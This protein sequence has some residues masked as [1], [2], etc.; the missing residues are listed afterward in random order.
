MKALKNLSVSIV[1]YNNGDYLIQ[2]LKSLKQQKQLDMDILVVDNAS[3]DGSLEKAKKDFPD[4][5]FLTNKE[6]LGFS[7]AHNLTLRKITSEFIL[8]L[9]PDTEIQ[10][11]DLVDLI[12]YMEDNPE[13]GA[14][15]GKVILPNGSLDW[16]SHRGFPTPWASLL[17]YFFKNDNLYHLSSKPLNQ[18]HEVDAISGSFF[19]TRKSILDKVGIFDED[20]FMYA[21]DIDL[22]FRI[23]QAGFKVMYKPTVEVLHHKGVSSGLKKHSQGIATANVETRKKAFDAFYQTM[24]IFYKKHLE[25]KYPFFINW[26]V[27]LG[28]NLKWWLAKRKLTV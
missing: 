6:N 2:C 27:Y 22:C 25:K 10:R 24:K 23:K 28:I 5:H 12:E 13:V 14:L 20:Y 11:G 16:A 4:I 8:I 9:N 3:T 15:T 19:L 21:E 26:L 18:T 1:N 7:K 17:Y